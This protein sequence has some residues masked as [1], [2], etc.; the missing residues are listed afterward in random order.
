MVDL[1]YPSWLDLSEYIHL[2]E[3]VEWVRFDFRDKEY[4]DFTPEQREAILVIKRKRMFERWMG[5]VMVL[6]ILFAI[7]LQGMWR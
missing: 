3:E 1:P 4:A 7:S 6:L 5:V 2:E